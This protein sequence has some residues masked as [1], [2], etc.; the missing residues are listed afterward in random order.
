[1]NVTLNPE[2]EQRIAEQV[3]LG[4]Y[5]TPAAVIEAAVAGLA[6]GLFDPALD[7]EDVAALNEAEAQIDRGEGMDLATLRA[8]MA[9]PFV[10]R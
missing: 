7:D 1:M 3:R 6:D 9:K 10:G 4:R 8:E 2:T 5:S